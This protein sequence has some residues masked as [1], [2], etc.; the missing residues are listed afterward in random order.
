MVIRGRRV[1]PWRSLLLVAGLLSTGC[2]GALGAGAAVVVIGAGAIAF[3][4]YDRVNVTVT[5]RLTG[6]KLCDAKVVFLQGK[7]QIETTS[8]GQ[9]ALSAGEY[10]LHVERRGLV[11]FEEPVS[12]T[13]TGECGG[14]IQTMYVALERVQ[15]P[16]AVAAPAAAAPVAAPAAPVPTAPPPVVPTPAAPAPAAAPTT[17]PTATSSAPP[18]LPAPPAPATNSGAFPN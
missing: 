6:A 13:K 3:T 1:N 11:P 8:C 12:V 18:T 2:A 9:A 7:S 14:T 10:R 4:C 15:P 17:P 16:G 5:D